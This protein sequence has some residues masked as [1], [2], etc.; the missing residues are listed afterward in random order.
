MKVMVCVG[1]RGRSDE[2]NVKTHAPVLGCDM[3]KLQTYTPSRDLS[4]HTS[5]GHLQFFASRPEAG[6]L[7]KLILAGLGKLSRRKYS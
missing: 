3:Y 7:K 1:P 4:K 2:Q 5:A 6:V